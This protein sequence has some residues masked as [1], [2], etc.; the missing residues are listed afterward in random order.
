MAK[1]YIRPGMVDSRFDNQTHY[2]GLM[3]LYRL[4]G[5]TARDAE[6]WAP[7]HKIHKDDVVLRPS[8][9]GDYSLPEKA[10]KIL[11]ARNGHG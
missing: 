1:I 9:E 5:L 4:Y 10:R 11:E 8:Y 7:W 2:V 3:E 6:P